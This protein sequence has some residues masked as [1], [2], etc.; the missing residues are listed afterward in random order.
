MANYFGDSVTKLRAKDGLK[1]GTF[2]V[3]TQPVAAV[4]RGAKYLGGERGQQ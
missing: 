1:M 3:G 4:L 2:A